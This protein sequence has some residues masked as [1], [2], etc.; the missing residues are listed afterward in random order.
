MSSASHFT[1]PPQLLARLRGIQH[2]LNVEVVL[3][4]LGAPLWGAA[5]AAAAWRLVVRAH[6]PIAAAVFVAFALAFAI[7]RLRGR[8]YTLQHA[9]ALG[10]AGRTL[11]VDVAWRLD[12]EEESVAAEAVSAFRAVGK[13]AVE[14]VPVLLTLRDRGAPKTLVTRATSLLA[15]IGPAARDAVPAAHGESS[16]CRTHSAKR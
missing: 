13:D 3:G 15:S 5:F 11:A 8:L 10:M 2:R 4:G 7:W 1:P 9:A 6:A 14:A 12:D 16:A